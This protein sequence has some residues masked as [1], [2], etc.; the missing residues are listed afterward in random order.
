[1]QYNEFLELVRKRRSIRRF[2]PDPI[3]DDYIEKMIEV[4]R[5]A[6]SGGNGQPWEFIAVKDQDT[7]K[8]IVELIIEQDK[9]VWDIEKTREKE[10]RHP[11]F[12][13]SHGKPIEAFQDAPVFIVVCGDPRAVQATVL[14]AHFLLIEGGPFAHFMKNIANA[15]TL[16]HLAAAS[17]GLGSMWVSIQNTIEPRL[18]D[19][20][21]LPVELAIHTIVPVGY[22]AFI[23]APPYRRPVK[24]ILHYEK[25]DRSKYRSG[26]DIVSFMALVR[27]RTAANYPDELEGYVA[28]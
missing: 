27:K 21:D 3:P 22:P 11:A 10:L 25:Y 6:M 9:Y 24:E 28:P 23:P 14:A 13:V 2:K 16:L 5:W 26:D 18:K 20:L 7:K 12:R 15:T 17:L 4:A 1:M 19:L 8:R